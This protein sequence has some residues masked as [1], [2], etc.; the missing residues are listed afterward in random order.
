MTDYPVLTEKHLEVIK[1]I[2]LKNHPKTKNDLESSH[3]IDFGYV[4]EEKNISFRV[5]GF[6]A[7]GKLGF[8]LRRIEKK[9]RTCEEL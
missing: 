8:S 1:D 6:W 9:A 3:D 7:L 2:L 5:N 4:L